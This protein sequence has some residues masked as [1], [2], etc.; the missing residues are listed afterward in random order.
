MYQTL[1]K[2]QESGP[3][4]QT[5]EPNKNNLENIQL[6]RAKHTILATSNMISCQLVI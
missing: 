5:G 3:N 1:Y 4:K 6:D 2:N